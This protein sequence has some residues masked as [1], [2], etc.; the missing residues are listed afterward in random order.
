MTGFVSQLV[1]LFPAAQEDQRALYKTKVSAISA[2]QNL[3]LLNE[4]ACKDNKI[5]A[6]EVK[7]EMDSRSYNVTDWIAGGSMKMWVEMIMR[8]E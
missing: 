8:S 6:A 7:K 4:I 3:T 5:L 1:D 2:T